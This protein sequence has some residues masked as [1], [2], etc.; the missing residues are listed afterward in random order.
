MRS[1]L[2]YKDV[3]ESAVADVFQ[4]KMQ[5]QDDARLSE[6][7]NLLIEFTHRSMNE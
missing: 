7:S 1:H 2:D 5:P 4:S 6:I 3:F